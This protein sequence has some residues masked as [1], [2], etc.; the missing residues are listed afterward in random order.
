MKIN[1]TYKEF[2]TLSNPRILIPKKGIINFPVTVLS[3]GTAQGK[4]SFSNRNNSAAI[5]IKDRLQQSDFTGLKNVRG[6]IVLKGESSS[7]G[8]LLA[9]N[10][11]IPVVSPYPPYMLKISNKACFLGKRELT[12]GNN[13]TIHTPSEKLFIGSVRLEKSMEE[14]QYRSL[15]QSIFRSIGKRIATFIGSVDQASGIAATGSGIAIRS[16]DFICTGPGQLS[17]FQSFVIA[18]Q[19]GER[20]RSRKILNKLGNLQTRQ[21]ESVFTLNADRPLIIRLFDPPFSEFF[22]SSE[23][24]L[25]KKL[26]VLF[27]QNP[28]LGHRGVR[29][30]ITHPQLYKMQAKSLL[31]ALA[32]AQANGVKCMPHFVVPMIM[33]PQEFLFVKNLYK[34]EAELIARRSGFMPLYK[35]GAAIETPRLLAMIKDVA[36]SADFLSFGTNDLTQLFFGLSRTDYQQFLPAY[37]NLGI[38]KKDPFQS[39]DPVIQK[40]IQEAAKQALAVNKKLSFF[41]AAKSQ[42]DI[43]F[44]LQVLGDRA[45]IVASPDKSPFIAFQIAKKYDHK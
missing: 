4:I 41:I 37:K 10:F 12:F 15:L 17:L 24:V 31:S 28:M 42:A 34:K 30:A 43:D 38:L 45:S 1:L 39:I 6:V 3:P 35:I 13:L 7:P 23:R 16:E 8:I 20:Q 33:D 25:R 11:N 9:R 21:Y 19:Q 14:H 32:R 18:S 2:E 36:K 29:L 22:S 44:I 27:E 5:L 26:P 40:N